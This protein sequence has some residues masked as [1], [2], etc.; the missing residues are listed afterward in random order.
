VSA[1]TGATEDSPFSIS[2]ARLAAA[3]DETDAQGDPISFRVESVTSGTL[4][5]NGQPVVAGTTKLTEGEQLVWTPAPNANGTLAAFKVRAV[6]A[7]LASSSDVQVSVAVTAV[8]DAPA[9]ASPL[10][11]Q[12]VAAGSSLN[13]TFS[14]TS[15]SDVDSP[16]LT[17]S[18][19]LASGT[20]L[21]A[22]LSFNA[23]SRT[24]GGT[25]STGDAGAIDVRVTASDG[26]LS[27]SDEFT[28]TV[29]GTPRATGFSPMDG[30][31]SV[32]VGSNLAIT[33]SSPIQL[34]SGPITLKTADGKVVETFTATNATVSGS[35]LTLN[36]SA[37]LSIFTKYVVELG[38]RSM[39]SVAILLAW[40][41]RVPPAP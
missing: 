26:S 39:S 2:W 9:V 20:A 14:A 35:A 19:S 17:Y 25:P 4:T 3:A 1:L 8:N 24:F 18:A 29:G 15:F 41:R 6:D 21:P 31:K 28:L 30:A 7:T 13:F 16:V 38:A 10:T 33:F 11:D 34:G 22:W 37:D 23:S 32:P 40:S 36:P 5:K 12:S 27:V